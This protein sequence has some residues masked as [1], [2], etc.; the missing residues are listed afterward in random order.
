[1]QEKHKN[2]CNILI[3]NLTISKNMCFPK[4]AYKTTTSI[5]PLLPPAKSKVFYRRKSHLAGHLHLFQRRSVIG[6]KSNRGGDITM[7]LSLK[8]K[9]S[10]GY[11][12]Q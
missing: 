3:M 2:G 9:G 7:P 4:N 8:T 12:D 11:R 1:M 6:W 10:A 5:P